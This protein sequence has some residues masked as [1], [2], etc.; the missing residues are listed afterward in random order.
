MSKSDDE[1]VKE[2]LYARIR[3]LESIVKHKNMAL[4]LSARF[5][6]E[7]DAKE[8]NNPYKNRHEE[9]FLLFAIDECDCD[10]VL[11]NH[12][13]SRQVK[14]GLMRS[15]KYSS[16]SNPT[17]EGHL[18][19][20]YP[21]RSDREPNHPIFA[22]HI[23]DLEMSTNASNRLLEND[24]KTIG[25]L[26]RYSRRELQRMPNLGKKTLLEISDSLERVGL[27]IH[28]TEKEMIAESIYDITFD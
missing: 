7:M 11:N 2:S 8:H 14:E 22:R 4:M 9:A 3:E 20:L 23:Y 26:V 6:T 5:I 12:L 19:E 21:E 27:A 15:F 13:D 28:M 18:N 17:I 1:I 25:S 16:I 10:D 24:I